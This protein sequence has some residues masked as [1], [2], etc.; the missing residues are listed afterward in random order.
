MYDPYVKHRYKN[1]PEPGYTMENHFLSSI[2]FA[3]LNRIILLYV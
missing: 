1:P 3:T 2:L